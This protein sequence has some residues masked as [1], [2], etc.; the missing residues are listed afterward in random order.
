[1][2][3]Y[4]DNYK[5]F[6]T[7]YDKYNHINYAVACTIILEHGKWFDPES[8]VESVEGERVA[9]VVLDVDFLRSCIFARM[10][11]VCL[12]NRIEKSEDRSITLLSCAAVFR[13]SPGLVCIRLR[14]IAY[15]ALCAEYGRRYTKETGSKSV[16]PACA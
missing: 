4:A 12:R 15:S 8:I 6:K 1:M 3:E 14:K 10:A 5:L 7:A 13:E 11:V 2:A 9:G 16:V